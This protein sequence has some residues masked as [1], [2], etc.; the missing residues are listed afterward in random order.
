MKHSYPFNPLFNIVIEKFATI[1]VCTFIIYLGNHEPILWESV[2][3][4]L[5]ISY[6]I[7]YLAWA[8]IMYSIYKISL[9]IV[10]MK[11]RDSANED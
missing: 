11:N 10:M 4:E 6:L 8:V 1:L 7:Y 3:E 5:N 9:A 2:L